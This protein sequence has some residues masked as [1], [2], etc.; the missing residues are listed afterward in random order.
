[1][2]KYQDLPVVKTAL[3]LLSFQ[4][5]R[6][7]L[8]SLDRRHLAFGLVCTWIV[9]M[10]RYWDAPSATLLQHLGVGSLVY[11]F[12]LSLL[13]WLIGC[14]L[15]PENWSYQRVLTFVSLTSPP[16]ILYAIPVERI[17]DLA[18]AQSVN[19]W[20]LALVAV[21]R[22]S[23]LAFFLVRLARLRWYA[24]MVA[25]LL[26]LTGVIAALTALNFEQAVFQAMAGLRE[27]SGPTDA[28]TYV[29]VRFLTLLSTVL[30]TPLLVAHVTLQAIA[31]Q[32]SFGVA[33]MS[34]LGRKG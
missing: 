21:W 23:L 1:M 27:S 8:L 25:T 22:V 18:T 12:G 4:I 32:H 28:G 16:A 17:F 33:L 13:I 15:A 3:R 9:G 30:L 5:S 11:V 19:V 2:R 7:E 20:F 34:N 31:R 6:E 14:P 26:P 29:V 10:G 24:V